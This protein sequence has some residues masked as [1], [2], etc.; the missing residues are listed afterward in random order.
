MEGD[1][2][3]FMKMVTLPDYPENRR[4]IR[5]KNV[6]NHCNESAIKA[7]FPGDKNKQND[8]NHKTINE[9]IMYI[10]TH[11]R[12]MCSFSLFRAR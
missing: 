10:V 3:D 7:F 11:S 8:G 6:P 12:F 5:L 4:V 2:Y 1:I 9:C